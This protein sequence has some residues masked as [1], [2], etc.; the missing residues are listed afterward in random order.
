MAMPAN[1]TQTASIGRGSFT[2]TQP[3][4]QHGRTLTETDNVYMTLLAMNTHPLHFDAA[5]ANATQWKRPLMNSLITISVVTGMSVHSTS[6]NAV[7]NLGW[8][9]VRL[10]NP[11]FAGDTLYAETTV[12]S[13]RESASRPTQGLVTVHTVGM[14]VDG[15]TGESGTVVI[16][17]DRT[18][19]VYKRE[20]SP[21]VKASY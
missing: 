13:K 21:L 20:H 1:R 5:Y 11:V 6:Q 10:V 16:E 15:Q 9:K 4:S 14:K 8:D 12:V 19:L 3:T 18:F 17:F 2:I 7:A